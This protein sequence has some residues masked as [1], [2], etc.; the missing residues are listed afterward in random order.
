MSSSYGGTIVK[1]GSRPWPIFT[2][3]TNAFVIEVGTTGKRGVQV[4][5]TEITP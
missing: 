5:T 3:L 2:I 4:W 1:V